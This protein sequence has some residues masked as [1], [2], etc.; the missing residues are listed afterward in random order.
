LFSVGQYRE[1]LSPY[2]R[3]TLILV[4][5]EGELQF[6]LQA[7]PGKQMA[8]PDEFVARWNAS[9]DAVAFFD[10]GVWESYQRRGFPGR[11]IAADNYTVAVSRL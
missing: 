7:E 4:S 10:P 2:L 9:T 3:R 6:G 1:T 11:V 8:T 5:F